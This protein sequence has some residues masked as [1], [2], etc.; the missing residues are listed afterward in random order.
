MRS[1]AIINNI[2]KAIHKQEPGATAILYGSQAR[3][4]AMPDSDIDVLILLDGEQLSDERQDRVV[5]PLYDIEWETGVQISPMVML[6]KTW[7][8]RPFKTPFYVNVINEGIEI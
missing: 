4:D 6:R 7:E 1:K 5:S 8:N 3:G 2:S